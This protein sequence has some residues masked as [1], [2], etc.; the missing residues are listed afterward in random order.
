MSF[1]NEKNVNL[2][3]NVNNFASMVPLSSIPSTFT[4]RTHA[5]KTIFGVNLQRFG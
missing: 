2:V 3:E 5:N 4:I 1:T